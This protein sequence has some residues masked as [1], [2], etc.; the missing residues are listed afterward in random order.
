MWLCPAASQTRMRR[1]EGQT[2]EISGG[3]EQKRYQA[4]VQEAIQIVQTY[5]PDYQSL[6]GFQA[7][8]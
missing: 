6:L 4:C 1:S 7:S 2:E 8:S 3:E 5:L